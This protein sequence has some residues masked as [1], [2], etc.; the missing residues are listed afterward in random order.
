MNIQEPEN[1]F[2]AFIFY[3]YNFLIH[4]QPLVQLETGLNKGYVHTKYGGNWI[5]LFSDASARTGCSWSFLSVLTMF[6]LASS[7][8]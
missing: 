1:F 8:V 4:L 3:F 6:V 2:N 5:S 7:I